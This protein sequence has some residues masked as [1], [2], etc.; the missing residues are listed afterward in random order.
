MREH[1]R[2]KDD[3]SNR[4]KLRL[5]ED[6]RRCS[7]Q[8]VSSRSPPKTSVKS[9]IRASSADRLSITKR[10]SD[11]PTKYMAG[12]T[13][14][15]VILRPGD[16]VELL[17]HGHFHELKDK[18]VDALTASPK[19]SQASS[20]HGEV[21]ESAQEV[22]R[23]AISAYLRVL[24]RE[25]LK[26]P[27][28]FDELLGRAMDRHTK[29]LKHICKA[30]IDVA[31]NTPHQDYYVRSFAHYAKESLVPPTRESLLSGSNS[32]PAARIIQNSLP[33]QQKVS[34][35]GGAADMNPNEGRV[36][37]A[38]PRG[39]DTVIVTSN[40]EP[41]PT[42]R[43]CLMCDQVGHNTTEC[44]NY[45][46][47]ETRVCRLQ[48]RRICSTCLETGHDLTKCTLKCFCQK[49]KLEGHTY[50]LCA[51]N[52]TMAS[53]PKASSSTTKQ[54]QVTQAANAPPQP[55]NLNELLMMYQISTEVAIQ[56]R[57]AL[58]EVLETVLPD[59]EQASLMLG[60]SASHARTIADNHLQM[61]QICETKKAVIDQRIAYWR[62]SQ[63]FQTRLAL[64]QNERN[65]EQTKENNDQVK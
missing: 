20:E 40:D 29:K 1:Q 43:Q 56:N 38:T 50:I 30:K 15:R 61:A 51:K 28:N 14:D 57:I 8:T 34:K 17:P 46:T 31:D 32:T 11:S 4:S 33:L 21:I 64:F 13:P 53:A 26:P 59:L 42:V 2:F 55:S 18:I 23:K 16:D 62:N 65:K 45:H 58:T 25:N 44:P 7:G 48:Q 35:P 9:V 19:G 47:Y 27:K 49:C 52:V 37:E 63:F 41:A 10:K 39:T 22:Q 54:Q 5:T 60:N 6:R 3:E 12:R 36:T 24:S